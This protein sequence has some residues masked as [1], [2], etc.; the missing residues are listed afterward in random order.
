MIGSSVRHTL[1]RRTRLVAG[2]LLFD[3]PSWLPVFLGRKRSW[4]GVRNRDDELELSPDGDGAR[5]GGIWTSEIHA[6]RVL[7][8][9]GRLLFRRSFEAHPISLA[10]APATAGEPLASVV[11]GHRGLDRLP[12]LQATLESFAAQRATPLECIV[13]EQSPRPEIRERIPAWV[14]YAHQAWP[15]DKPFGRSHAFNLGA[16]LAATEILVFHDNDMLVPE[17][18]VAGIAAAVTKGFL[19]VNLKRFVFYLDQPSTSRIFEENWP[20]REPSFDAVTQNLLGGGSMAATRAGF[21]AIGGFDEGFVGWGGEDEEFWE[22]VRTL[23]VYSW[24]CLPIAHLWHPAQPGKTRTK[25][26][27]GM[28]RLEERR[29]I[30]VSVRISE[31]RAVSRRRSPE[32]S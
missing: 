1:F 5:V 18:Y 2:V 11:I 4:F 14:R 29:R 22:R 7:P 26:T 17:D 8:F 9:L 3:L 32:P 6:T 19:F 28:R 25:Q 20:P 12:H 15:D 23:P 13:V 30:P 10:Q 24:G 21:E 31:L 16:R 27:P